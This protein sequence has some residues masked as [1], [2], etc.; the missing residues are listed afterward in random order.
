[1]AR[2]RTEVSE[3]IDF[4]VVTTT[5]VLYFLFRNQTEG[6][7]D[8]NKN[9]DYL[10]VSNVN[11]TC[12]GGGYQLERDIKRAVAIKNNLISTYMMVSEAFVIFLMFCCTIG[13]VI[14]VPFC[15]KEHDIPILLRRAGSNVFFDLLTI[16]LLI[17]A[18]FLVLT[19]SL[20]HLTMYYLN[21][22]CLH[23]TD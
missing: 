11:R 23:T 14:Y 16:R 8:V 4:E 15:L 7:A 18:Y 22:A 19:G 21:D 20:P 5:K 17:Y 1:M 13:A 9:N 12:E 10:I 2:A 6:A 3:T